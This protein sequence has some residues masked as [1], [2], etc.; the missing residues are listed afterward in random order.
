MRIGEIVGEPLR[1][2]RPQFSAAERR[3]QALRM[4]ERVG[5]DSGHL[6]RYDMNSRAVR[7]SAS[8]SPGH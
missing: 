6:D 2:F 1:E 4:L 3:H 8:V 5:L 7:R